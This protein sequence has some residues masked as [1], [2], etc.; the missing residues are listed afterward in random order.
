MEVTPD[1]SADLIVTEGFAK[2][3]RQP[4]SR[5]LCES[6]AA[7]KGEATGVS[8][9]RLDG[10]ARKKHAPHE[11]DRARRSESGVVKRRFPRSFGR[12]CRPTDQR[13]GVSLEEM[14]GANEARVLVV[15]AVG[16]INRSVRIGVDA[17]RHVARQTAEGRPSSWQ[18]VE[19]ADAGNGGSE[20]SRYGLSGR[21][22]SVGTS[23]RAPRSSGARVKRCAGV[24]PN[25]Q[26]GGVKFDLVRCRKT[27]GLRS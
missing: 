20:M 19:S 9:A 23:A 24:M 6:A 22:V 27:P 25:C 14:P 12:G 18:A 10:S 15:E 1:R 26:R 16:S 3:S 5:C 17:S 13:R 4:R 2:R 11:S 8:E 7:H 21:R